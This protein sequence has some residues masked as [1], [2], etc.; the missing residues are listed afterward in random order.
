MSARTEPIEDE[1]EGHSSPAETASNVKLRPSDS[2]SG[3]DLSDG[4]QRPVTSQQGQL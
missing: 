1:V 3:S 2:S 4:L